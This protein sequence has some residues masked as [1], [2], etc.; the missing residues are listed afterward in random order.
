MKILYITI[1]FLVIILIIYYYKKNK[2]KSEQF[3]SINKFNFIDNDELIINDN[4]G[5]IIISET[6]QE[7]KI[8]KYIEGFTLNLS[9]NEKFTQETKLL[10][11]LFTPRNVFTYWE[12]K[13]NRTEPYS[14]IKLCFETMKK[15]YNKYNFVILTPKTIKEYLPNIRT[16]LDNLL[17]AQKV[18]YYRVA[19][20]SIYGGI[21]IDA[22]TIVL[23]DLDNVFNKLDN[24]YDFVGFG[25]TGIKCFNGSPYP[26]NGVMGSRKDGL[27]ITSCLEKLNKKLDSN[28]KKHEYFDLGKKIIWECLEELQPYDYYHFTSEIDGSRDINGNWIHTPQH[29]SEN[30]TKLLNEEKAL[31]I[32]LANYEIMNDDKYKWFLNMSD[33]EILNGKWWISYLY[34][35]A[36]NL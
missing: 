26:S 2:D 9:L 3:K 27:L 5:D 17:I 31:F 10:P 7:N 19:L 13:D 6:N 16:D 4:F 1:I 36:L 25:C 22:D 21:W 28:N 35:K 11:F 29:L 34:R 14:H 30:P 12:N 20:L 32:F 15:H 8:N 24:G 18:D 33:N 23:K